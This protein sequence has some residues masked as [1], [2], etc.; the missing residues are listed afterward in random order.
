[1]HVI[2]VLFHVHPMLHWSILAYVLNFNKKTI[3]LIFNINK[4]ITKIIQSI[5]IQLSKRTFCSSL[6]TVT[7]HVWRTSASNDVKI[8]VFWTFHRCSP[9]ALASVVGIT[10]PRTELVVPVWSA[11]TAREEPNVHV[12]GGWYCKPLSTGLVVWIRLCTPYMV[13]WTHSFLY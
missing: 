3:P 1:M 5:K 7:S 10:R 12:V 2:A 8:G 13:Y 9:P 6:S 11:R 4:L